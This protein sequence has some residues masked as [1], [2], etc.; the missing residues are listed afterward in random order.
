MPGR[1]KNG[2]KQ[3]RSLRSEWKC[4]KNG[5]S[6]GNSKSESSDLLAGDAVH[7]EFA[8]EEEAE[9]LVEGDGVGVR[10]RDVEVGVEM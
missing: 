8:G 3:V 7:D 5:K 4:K 1:V 2:R 10:G 9:A 6:N